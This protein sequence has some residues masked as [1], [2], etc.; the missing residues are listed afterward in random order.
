MSNLPISNVSYPT[1]LN[2]NHEIHEK[3]LKVSDLTAVI[4]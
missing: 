2:N 4:H 3:A 1:F